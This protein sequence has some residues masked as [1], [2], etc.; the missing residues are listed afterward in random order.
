MPNAPYHAAFHSPAQ[1][2]APLGQ[3]FHQ[4]TESLVIA[5]IFA[6]A[7][8]LEHTERNNVRLLKTNV[9]LHTAQAAG[10][11]VR[12]PGTGR[13]RLRFRDVGHLSMRP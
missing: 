6:A 2:G 7:L 11:T 12:L 13:L 4:S 9:P 10:P 8:Q 5:D 3:Q 1:A